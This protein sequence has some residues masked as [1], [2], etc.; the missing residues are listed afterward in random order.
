MK[1]VIVGGGS[2]GW[3]SAATFISQLKGSQITLVESPN[4]PSIGVGESTINGLIKWM[5]LLNIDPDEVVK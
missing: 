1:I 2:A 5:K 3:M 4:I